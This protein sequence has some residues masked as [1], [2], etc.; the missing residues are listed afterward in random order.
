MSL[1]DELDEITQ[2]FRESSHIFPNLEHVIVFVP[3][4]IEKTPHVKRTWGPEPLIPDRYKLSDGYATSKSWREV[5]QEGKGTSRSVVRQAFHFPNVTYLPESVVYRNVGIWAEWLRRDYGKIIDV[6]DMVV[7]EIAPSEQLRCLQ[8]FTA[9]ARRAGDCVSRNRQVLGLPNWIPT[10]PDNDGDWWDRRWLLAMF[11]TL[12]KERDRV[13]GGH[14]FFV[15]EDC[16]LDSVIALRRL[17]SRMSSVNAIIAAESSFD[18]IGQNADEA[19]NDREYTRILN[20]VRSM[21]LVIERNPASFR[22]LN[23]EQIRDHFLVHLNG[24]Y[25]GQATGETFNASGKTDILVRRSDSNVCIVECKFWQ[26]STNFNEA[27]D[28][29]LRYLTWRDRRCALI[30]FNRNEDALAVA[31]KMH[32]IME[33]RTELVT[34]LS[35]ESSADSRYV[36]SKSDEPNCR[37]IVT[38]LLF[39]L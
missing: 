10:E 4:E 34:T 35:H 17:V 15:N 39:N 33:G 38:T 25:H 27:I 23:E 8:R 1:G 36:L 9:L 37:I 20:V 28:Q 5:D 2:S 30:V 31:E 12:Q 6:N 14:R 18:V 32:K 26:G 22:A 7:E 3:D 29:L 21:S 16:F 24:Y 19:S 11:Y 13:A